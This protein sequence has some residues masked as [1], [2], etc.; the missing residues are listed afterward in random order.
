MKNRKFSIILAAV[1]IGFL[2]IYAT[3]DNTCSFA[4]DSG[5][6]LLTSVNLQSGAQQWLYTNPG[7]DP[8]TLDLGTDQVASLTI[9]FQFS[10][11]VVTVQAGSNDVVS[12]PWG[13]TMTVNWT[14]GDNGANGIEIDPDSQN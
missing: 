6:T 4:N 8:T 14:M 2:S 3:D 5:Y 1:V 12:T 13:T 7:D 9:Y 10:P 11:E